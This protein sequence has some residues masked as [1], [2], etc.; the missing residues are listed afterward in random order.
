MKKYSSGQGLVEYA[1]LLALIAAGVMLSLSA[2]GINLHDVY[3]KT[4]ESLGKADAC[5][6]ASAQEFCGDDFDSGDISDWH[7]RYHPPTTQEGQLCMDHYAMMFNACSEKKNKSDYTV[8]VENAVLTKGNGYGIFFR[9][10]DAEGRPNGYIFQYDPGYWGGAFLFRKWI[11]GRE[12]A[13]FAVVRARD[14]EW[15]NTPRDV[16]VVVQ[17]N[18]FT[19]YI[20][21]EEILTATDDTYTEGSAGLRTWDRTQVCFDKFSM[22]TS[23]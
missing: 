9:V 6:V 12:T 3:C 2:F 14:Y 7:S 19:A 13:P 11:H 16:K 15:Y 10:S 18:T 22:T 5:E 23:P 4:A 20:D 1:L 17:G 8:E 21:G